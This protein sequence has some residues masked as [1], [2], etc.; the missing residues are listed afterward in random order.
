[1]KHAGIEHLEEVW[2]IFKP[3]LKTYFPH[4]R[5]SY[6]ENCI[7]NDKVIYQDGIVIIYNRYKKKTK[8]GNCQ[9]QR[10]EIILKQ[11]VKD[12]MSNKDAKDAM[13]E[14][15]QY[16]NNNVWLTVRV[17]NHKAISLYEKTGMKKVGDI[18]WSSGKI[19][20]AI[21][22]KELVNKPLYRN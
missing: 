22:F 5:K 20:G 4:I 14:F 8:I 1:M 12:K 3:H 6:V 10:G 19:Q 18:N 17:D 9:C 16:V 21:F 15:F 7:K 13:F 2:Q 11:I